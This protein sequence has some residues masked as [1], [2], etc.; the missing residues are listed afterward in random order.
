M[1]LKTIN[2]S[3]Y[4][5]STFLKASAELKIS[6]EELKE[7]IRDTEE[8][9]KTHRIRTKLKKAAT[10]CDNPGIKQVWYK[11]LNEFNLK[12]VSTNK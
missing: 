5:D 1:S 10:S 2:I 6:D 3:K 12:Q 4:L 9:K 8:E 7:K 11:K